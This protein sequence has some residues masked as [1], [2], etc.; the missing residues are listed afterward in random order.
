MEGG[1]SLIDLREELDVS[2]RCLGVTR[3]VNLY[4]ARGCD[5]LLIFIYVCVCVENEFD[6]SESG[7]GKLS[8]TR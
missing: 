1:I 3:W 5:F 4:F 2:R 6:E 8:L 7:E